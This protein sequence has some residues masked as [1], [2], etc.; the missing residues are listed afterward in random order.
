MGTLNGTSEHCGSKDEGD[1]AEYHPC[2]EGVVVCGEE[3]PGNGGGY[4]S[5]EEGSERGSAGH[6]MGVDLLGGDGMSV[7]VPDQG[8]GGR[9]ETKES[10]GPWD[11]D[12]RE[13]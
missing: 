11:G 3:V 5:R 13:G 4:K 9:Q 6:T 12:L 8:H 7:V 2:R 1:C 10:W